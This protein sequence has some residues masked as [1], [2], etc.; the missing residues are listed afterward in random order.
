LAVRDHF[1]P[2][3]QAYARFRPRYPSELFEY[4]ATLVTRRDRAWDC[5]TGSGQAAVALAEFFGQVVASDASAR[6]IASAQKHPRVTYFVATGEQA[7]LADRSVDLVAIAQALHWLD[8]PRFYREARRV[9]RPGGIVAAW[10]YGLVAISPEIDRVIWRLYRDVL[11]SYWPEFAVA[12]RWNL[13]DLVGYLG[14]WSSVREYIEQHGS[15]P[16]ATVDAELRAAWG[17]AEMTRPV[18]WP[19]FLR[20]GRIE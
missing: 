11:G 10:G 9:V 13:S 19:V 2:L 16:L 8:R 15:S 20:V 7:P 1:S 17:P 12:A 4:L 3:A 18:R 5:A 14:T 6:Q